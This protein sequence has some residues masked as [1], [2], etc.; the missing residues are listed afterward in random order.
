MKKYKALKAHICRFND[1]ECICK[2]FDK[3]YKRGIKELPLIKSRLELIIGCH[4]DIAD[5]TLEDF[6]KDV[7]KI[8]N[9]I[10]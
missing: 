7:V 2:C 6:Y 3:G 5:Y 4:C 10:K 8:Y 9:D 1:G